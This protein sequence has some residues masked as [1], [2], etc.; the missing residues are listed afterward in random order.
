[1]PTNGETFYPK[2]G[3]WKETPLWVFFPN[4]YITELNRS[5]KLILYRSIRLWKAFY[6]FKLTMKLSEIHPCTFLEERNE[7]WLLGENVYVTQFCLGA[8]ISSNF[9]LFYKCFY[10]SRCAGL[11]HCVRLYPNTGTTLDL[12]RK[13]LRWRA[14]LSLNEPVTSEIFIWNAFETSM[15]SLKI[16]CV[17]NH[18]LNIYILRLPVS[19]CVC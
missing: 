7:F 10:N 3:H 8:K 1:M 17:S 9:R 16:Y 19:V 2:P 12:T 13:Y 14:S 15:V 4:N 6:Y 18:W 11:K 5:H